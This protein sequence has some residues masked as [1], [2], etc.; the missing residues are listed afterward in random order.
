MADKEIV[1]SDVEQQQI[2]GIVI[3]KDKEEA[4]KYLA[5]LVQRFKGSSESHACGP[6]RTQ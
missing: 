3:D 6:K 1:F 2:E 4:I 5:S